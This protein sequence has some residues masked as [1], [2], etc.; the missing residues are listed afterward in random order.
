MTTLI[1][2]PSP[3][4]QRKAAQDLAEQYLQTSIDFDHPP[5]DLHILDGANCN[6]LGI[7]QVK[8]IKRKLKYQPYEA[9]CQIG[10]ILHSNILTREAQNS[11]LKILE[12]PGEQTVWILTTQHEKLLLPTIISRAKKMYIQSSFDTKPDTEKDDKCEAKTKDQPETDIQPFLKMPVEDKI[13]YIEDLLKADKENP[14]PLSNFLHEI[15][16]R[17][18]TQL[19]NAIHSNSPEEIDSANSAIQKINK[20]IHFI[21]KNTNKRL[22]MENLILQLEDSIM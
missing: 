7:D 22:T 12:E 4:T 3:I 16:S 2:H 17:Y 21:S 20:A 9:K 6:S 19:I 5:T 14:G 18:R 8:E 11:L 15:L 10:L 13:L 1:I